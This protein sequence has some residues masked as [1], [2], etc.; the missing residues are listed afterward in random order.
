M[1]SEERI[2]LLSEHC[3]SYVLSVK[4]KTY[5]LFS[6]LFLFNLDLIFRSASNFVGRRIRSTICD[7]LF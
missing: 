7:S 4:A 2:D 3:H 5:F 6:S 1:N